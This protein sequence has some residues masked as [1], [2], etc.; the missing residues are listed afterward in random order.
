MDKAI[1]FWFDELEGILQHEKI[2][3]K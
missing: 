2:K 1:K 3:E